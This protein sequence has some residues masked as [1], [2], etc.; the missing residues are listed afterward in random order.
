MDN[1]KSNSGDQLECT[2]PVRS[3]FWEPAGDSTLLVH[4]KGRPRVQARARARA[5]AR[6]GRGQGMDETSLANRDR[7]CRFA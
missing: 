1:T 5:R 3:D 6:A 7:S 2:D 4:C